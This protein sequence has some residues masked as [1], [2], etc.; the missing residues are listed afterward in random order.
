MNQHHDPFFDVP[1]TVVTTSEGEVQLPICYVD[2]SH[3][4]ALFRV[5]VARAAARL[6]G[7][8][9]APVQVARK[10]VAILSFF[11]YRQTTLGPYHEVGLALLVT[12][13]GH[14]ATLGSLTEL[15]Q[16]TRSESLGSYV[17]DLPVSTA[18]AKAAGCELW[19]YPKFVTELPIALDGDRFQ[20]RV[21]D[22]DGGQIL[23]LSGQRGHV[24]PETLPGMALVTYSQLGDQYLRTRVET[25]TSCATG[26][27]GSLVL[28]VG[29]SSHRMARNLADLGLDG[30]TPKLFQSTEDFQ[31]LL[32]AGVEVDLVA[33]SR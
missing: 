14:E 10:A 30:Q 12:P 29:E 24:L 8:P 1:K 22:P 4:M 28:R 21:L 7:L 25:R 17:L 31:S 18:A 6:Q 32:F 5:D 33:E 19:G 2:C 15:L 16:Q 23:E 27:G 26:G 11:Q 20:A 3:Y 13:R 9:L